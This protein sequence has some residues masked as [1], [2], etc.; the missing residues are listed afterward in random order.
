MLF[1]SVTFFSLSSLILHGEKQNLGS[2]L[3][4]QNPPF[5][6]CHTMSTLEKLFMHVF[7]KKQ[8][9]SGQL[10]QQVNSYE[11]SVAC[12]LAASGR[13]LPSWLVDDETESRS[14]APVPDYSNRTGSLR[15]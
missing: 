5:S 1:R 3:G 9:I 4:F 15:I 10:R 14:D 12:N 8:W 6:Q 13:E 7:D 2:K 11:E